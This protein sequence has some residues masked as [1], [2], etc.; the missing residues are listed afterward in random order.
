MEIVGADFLDEAS[1]HQ[2]RRLFAGFG[3]HR[4]PELLCPLGYLLRL[5]GSI[6]SRYPAA[7]HYRF[8]HTARRYLLKSHCFLCLALLA[9]TVA[10]CLGPGI[11]AQESNEVLPLSQI[12]AGMQGYASTIFAGDQAEKFDLEVIGVLDNFLGPK[13]SI[14]LVQLKGPKVEHTGVVAGMSGSPVYLDGKLAGA[15]SLKLGIF[16]KE[17]I[18]GVTPIQDVLNPPSQL[19]AAQT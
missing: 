4:V 15:L 19:V 10:L 5:G 1:L 2:E 14:I 3:R 7:Y 16:T 9:F 11:V 17:P 18:A 8:M 12:R 6:A 13:Q